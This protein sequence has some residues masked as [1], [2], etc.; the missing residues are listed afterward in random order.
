MESDLL[1]GNN[2]YKEEG[3]FED[4]SDGFAKD[5]SGLHMLISD[6]SVLLVVLLHLH[7]DLVDEIS[8]LVDGQLFH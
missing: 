1:D 6:N 8:D 4:F 5:D 3:L 2:S 7:A